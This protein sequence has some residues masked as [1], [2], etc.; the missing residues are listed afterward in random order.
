MGNLHHAN[1]HH[2]TLIPPFQRAIFARYQKPDQPTKPKIAVFEDNPICLELSL[3]FLR[4]IG[5]IEIIPAHLITSLHAA[6]RVIEAT[7]PD[8]VLTDLSLA[9]VGYQGFDILKII[10]SRAARQGREVPVV[11]T[12]SVYYPGST[13]PVVVRIEHAGFDGVYNKRIFI[14][15]QL[16]GFPNSSEAPLQLQKDAQADLQSL[17]NQIES[18]LHQPTPIDQTILH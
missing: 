3:S 9:R 8:I 15:R 5:G 14:A 12:T 7:K 18:W 4:T 10:K 17:K 11:L 16:K 6:I 2:A 13:D 1:I